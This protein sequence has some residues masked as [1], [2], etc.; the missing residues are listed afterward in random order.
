MDDIS[1]FLYNLKSVRQLVVWLN[2]LPL[3]YHKMPVKVRQHRMTADTID[4]YLMLWLWKFGF[5]ERFEREVISHYCKEGMN[6]LYLGAN[7]G[8]Y[9]L[10]L[11]E[12]VG[13]TGRVIAFEPH[14]TNF[15]AL[16]R[17]ITMNQLNNITALNY[18]IGAKNGLCSLYVSSSHQGDHRIYLPQDEQREYI[19]VQ[20][21]ALDE[22]LIPVKY[23]TYRVL[24]QNIH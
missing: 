23:Y 11:S 9:T 5:Y 21:V 12:R 7:I 14:P 6:V 3:P 24:W 10:L 17:N 2:Q 1:Y 22:S 13:D 18:A 19:P 8:A 4:R 15:T 16:Q 20:M